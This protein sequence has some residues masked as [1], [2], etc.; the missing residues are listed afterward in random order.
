MIMQG[1]VLSSMNNIWAKKQTASEQNKLSL[2]RNN[3]GT[4]EKAF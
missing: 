3:K 1:N 4:A 2:T